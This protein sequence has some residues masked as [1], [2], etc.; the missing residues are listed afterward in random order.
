MPDHFHVLITP[1]GSLE[2]AVQ[3]IK[4]GFSFRAKKELSWTGEIWIAGFSDHR[5]RD[6]GDFEVHRRYMARNPVEAGLADQ[7]GSYAYCSDNGRFELDAFP[8]GLK[9]GSVGAASGAAKAAPFQNKSGGAKA[10]PFQ[11][12]S[13]DAEAAPCQSERG[14]ESR[15]SGTKSGESGTESTKVVEC[16]K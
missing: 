7:E 10:A 12:K 4:G 11:N 13:D 14:M 8:R 2:K 3:F 15:E 1:Q 6:D 16:V 5:I 9:P